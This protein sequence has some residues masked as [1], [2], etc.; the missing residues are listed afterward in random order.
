M[1]PSGDCLDRAFAVGVPVLATLHC[2]VLR[3]I[4]TSLIHW[5]IPCGRH[6]LSLL[7]CL[8]DTPPL[9][10]FLSRACLHPSNDFILNKHHVRGFDV[11]FHQTCNQCFEIAP[12]RPKKVADLL[13]HHLIV[14]PGF[15]FIP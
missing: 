15:L 6:P 4:I 5:F 9:L 7:L 3:L 1:W 12:M 8:L 11:T 13:M 10:S 2:Y 14:L